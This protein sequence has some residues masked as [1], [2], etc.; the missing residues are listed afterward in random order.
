MPFWAVTSCGVTLF[1][2]RV[3]GP[4]LGSEPL[5]SSVDRPSHLITR[6]ICLRVDSC[7]CAADAVETWY[8]GDG[9]NVW[10]RGV[11]VLVLSEYSAYKLVS[12]VSTCLLCLDMWEMKTF[13]WWR[14]LQGC[15]FYWYVM[16]A[17]QTGLSLTSSDMKQVYVQE[18]RF[19][20]SKLLKLSFHGEKMVSK[21][22]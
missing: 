4:A 20:A 1:P 3:D 7:T 8:W 14:A 17:W 12:C 11:G 18:C 19:K 10:E 22:C 21:L 6:A 2:V 13:A 15:L 5:W 16:F 9:G